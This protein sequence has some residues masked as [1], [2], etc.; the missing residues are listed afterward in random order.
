MSHR[1]VFLALA[2]GAVASPAYSQDIRPVS[3]GQSMLELKARHVLQRHSIAADPT[4]LSLPQLTRIV[5]AVDSDRD[6]PRAK[7]LAAV[8]SY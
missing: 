4:T 1:P 6:Q 7:I 5:A 3:Q 2:L 8:R